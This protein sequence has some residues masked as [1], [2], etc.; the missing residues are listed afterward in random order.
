MKTCVDFIIANN[1]PDPLICGFNCASDT[2]IDVNVMKVMPFNNYGQD[3]LRIRTCIFKVH[4]DKLAR[5]STIEQKAC[6][7]ADF[8]VCNRFIPPNT[9]APVALNINTTY[10]EI[11]SCT[12]TGDTNPSLAY[13]CSGLPVRI[14]GNQYVFPLSYDVPQTDSSICSSNG[15]INV[16]VKIK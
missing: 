15:I 4:A 10:I 11:D 6:G 5:Y 3:Y 1:C 2:I 16:I 14:Y 12:N 13:D 9:Y 7:P 8:I